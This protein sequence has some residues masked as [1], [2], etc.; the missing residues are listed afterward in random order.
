MDLAVLLWPHSW[1]LHF[2][3]AYVVD[4]CVSVTLLFCCVTQYQLGSMGLFLLQ[5]AQ[6]LC[7]VEETLKHDRVEAEEIGATISGLA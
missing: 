4:N 6:P 3:L 5:I 2:E 1:S 7:A